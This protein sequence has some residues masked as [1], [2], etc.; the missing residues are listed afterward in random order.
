[1]PFIVSWPAAIPPGR[2][3]GALVEAVDIAPTLLEA[4]G[5]PRAPGMQGLSLWPLLSG[6]QDLDQHHD[7]VY[8]EYYNASVM[9]SP[10]DPLAFLTMV[11]SERYK[12]VAVH[13]HRTGELY[14]LHEDPDETR[15]RWDDRAYR[16]VRFSMLETLVDRIAWTVDPLPVRLKHNPMTS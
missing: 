14:D 8:S 7:D 10:P 15:N 12:L 13:G 1:M 16:D 6:A 2:R 3:S 11:R 4:A 5:L 9:F